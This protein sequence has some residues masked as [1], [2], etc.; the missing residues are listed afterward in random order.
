MFLLWLAGITGYCMIFAYSILPFYIVIGILSDGP[1]SLV[2]YHDYSVLTLLR[3]WLHIS[4]TGWSWLAILS[5]LCLL[6]VYLLQ[7]KIIARTGKVSFRSL[8][9]RRVQCL[10]GL[11]V[12]IYAVCFV[13]AWR[14]EARYHRTIG[15]LETHFGRPL[16][17]KEL[18]KIYYDGSEPD[19]EYW[20]KLGTL[21]NSKIEDC[22]NI[23]LQL[24]SN[25]IFSIWLLFLFFI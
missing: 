3:D 18:E 21:S 16:T 17:F 10:L 11:C 1:E 25:S 7:A 15:E 6:C 12:L 4:G 5:F 9:G 20:K 24:L 8:F 2:Q 19:T 23:V 14:A 22:K 13:L